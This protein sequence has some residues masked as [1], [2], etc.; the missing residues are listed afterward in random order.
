MAVGDAH[1]VNPSP[2]MSERGHQGGV[3][4]DFFLELLVAAEVPAK[5]DL[6]EDEGA[7]FAAEGVDARGRVGRNFSGVDDVGGRPRSGCHQVV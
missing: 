7:V 6:E 2:I 1:E 3:L 4:I 5:A